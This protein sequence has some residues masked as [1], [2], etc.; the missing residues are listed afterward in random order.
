MVAIVVATVMAS[1]G[2]ASVE[3]RVDPSDAAE[4]YGGC[5]GEPGEGPG[6]VN[7][8]A[9]V[10]RWLEVHSVTDEMRALETDEAFEAVPTA[11]KVLQLEVS[12][13]PDGYIAREP[14]AIHSSYIPGI[15]ATLDAGGRVFLGLASEGLERETT[16]FA[17]ARPTESPSY[18]AGICQFEALTQPLRESLGDEYETALTSIIGITDPNEIAETLTKPSP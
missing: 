4:V 2:G 16:A 8:I 3:G 14:V 10:E 9:V 13:L 7:A 12:E 15:D 1:C 5:R 17:L 18:F 11:T 6:P